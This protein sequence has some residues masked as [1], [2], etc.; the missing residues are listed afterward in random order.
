MEFD[1]NAAIEAVISR[2]TDL[3]RAE[4]ARFQAEQMAQLKVPSALETKAELGRRMAKSAM[5]SLKNQE[6]DA[7]Y[8]KLA[9]GLALQGEYRAAAELTRNPCKKSA[10]EAI[11]EALENPHDCGCPLMAGR[12]PTRFI[13]ERIIAE[14]RQVDVTACSL[15]G[16]IRC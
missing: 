6:S 10:Y 3:E 5:D 11:I 4:E 9:E 12:N 7:A 8:S 2:K 13:K 16:H 1:A 15:C 14:G